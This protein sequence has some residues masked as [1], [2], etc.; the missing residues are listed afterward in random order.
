MHAEVSHAFDARLRRVFGAAGVPTLP[1]R[2]RHPP[3]RYVWV[4]S[5]PPFRKD[6]LR[7]GR[8]HFFGRGNEEDLVA[9]TAADCIRAP[10]QPDG[11]SPAR[12]FAVEMVRAVSSWVRRGPSRW[13]FDRAS[14]PQR[15]ARAPYRHADGF[16]AYPYSGNLLL[17]PR[18]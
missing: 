14:S 7:V 15:A 17:V 16:E 18:S 9:S 10:P 13:G 3:S 5:A 1:R 12:S 11:T 6:A 4:P 2:G 8:P